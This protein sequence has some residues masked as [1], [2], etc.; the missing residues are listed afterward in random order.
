MPMPQP[1]DRIGAAGLAGDCLGRSAGAVARARCGRRCQPRRCGMRRGEADAGACRGA[2][3][4][5]ASLLAA[6]EPRRA[7]A[8]LEFQIAMLE[9]G[10]FSDP[11]LAL[12]E[13]GAGGGRLERGARRA[14]R[15][16]RRCRR[17]LFPRPGGRSRRSARPRAASAC[18]GEADAVAAG[19]RHPDR[20]RSRAVRF[21]AIDW[22]R[23]GAVILER[24]SA[25][26]PC[27]HPGAGARRADGRR[28]RTAFRRR[29]CRSDRSMGERRRRAVAG[30]C[31]RGAR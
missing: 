18:A 3:P 8:I 9:D 11:A 21:L 24:G 26:Q 22:S 25:A 12:I 10:T 1:R 23:G 20:R 16:L 28:P 2:T 31:S 29:P 7:A 15:R 13:G 27:R 6:A 4:E 19:R 14:D 5:L 30:S 17:R